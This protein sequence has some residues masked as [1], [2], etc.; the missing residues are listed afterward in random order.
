[1]RYDPSD[2]GHPGFGGQEFMPEVLEKIRF[3]RDVCNQSNIRDGG[4]TGSDKEVKSVPEFDIEVDG[5]IDMETGRRCVE[6]GANILVAGTYLFKQPDMKKAVK[7]LSLCESLD[8][9]INGNTIRGIQ[10]MVV[11]NNITPGM[12]LSISGKL[13]R[14]ESAVKVTVPKGTPFIKTKL[15]ELT[16]TRWLK[17]TLNSIRRL[18]MCRWRKEP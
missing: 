8:K 5:G 14:V 16:L 11:S 9:N 10:F 18:K 13:Y 4:R 7:E 12:T 3:T 6:A 15:R 2:D 17:R 1:M